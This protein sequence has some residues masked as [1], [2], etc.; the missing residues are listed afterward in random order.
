MSVVGGNGSL[1]VHMHQRD[2][3][4]HL[5]DRQMQNGITLGESGAGKAHSKDLCDGLISRFIL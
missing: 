5:S 4:Q 2:H 1:H 3:P